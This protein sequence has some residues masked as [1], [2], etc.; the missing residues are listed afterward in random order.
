M[1]RRE[2]VQQRIRLTHVDDLSV[3]NSALAEIAL[4]RAVVGAATFTRVSVTERID[5]RRGT[6]ME[7]M[8]FN[9][10][11]SVGA[12]TLDRSTT[13]GPLRF[14]GCVFR[15][16]VTFAKATFQAPMVLTDGAFDG[17]LSLDAVT[18]LAPIAIERSKTG[19]EVS[20]DSG[21]YHHGL[22]LTRLEATSAV[23]FVDA[24]LLSPFLVEDSTFSGPLTL[25]RLRSTGRVEVRDVTFEDAVSF[26]SG[27]YADAVVFHNVEFQREVTFDSAEF[28]GPV[29]FRDVRFLGPVSFRG[30][31]FGD[32]LRFE[33]VRFD[34]AV[35]FDIEV[36]HLALVNTT[37]A[38]QAS[39][40][41]GNADV[42]VERSRFAAPVTLDSRSTC[43]IRSLAGT[44]ATNLTLAMVDLGVCALSDVY[45]LDKLRVEAAAFPE[46]P[47][48]LRFSRRWPWVLKRSK[49][50]IVAEEAM[51]RARSAPAD[52]A[53]L[54]QGF[55][56]PAR[57]VYANDVA[58]VY[59]QLRKAR[60][61]AKDEPNAA[62]FYYGEMEMRRRATPRHSAEGLILR[63]YWLTSGYGLRGL[64]SVAC[65]VVL[66]LVC[67]TLMNRFGFA[68]PHTWP[69]SVV[70]VAD[71]ATK[72]V[73]ASSS[74]RLTGWG[75]AL[76]VVVRLAGPVLLG[77]AILSVRGRA[78]R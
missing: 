57:P 54:L 71:A 35:D 27:S 63:L 32:R 78:K 47:H 28:G 59:R 13:K 67:A 74:D 41:L 58:R 70:H 25:D 36:R 66:L 2:D 43:R 33:H 34:G 17:K 6:L 29:T 24:H 76:Q 69:A 9:K 60:E 50:R 53:P 48:R 8:E 14:T 45:N 18:A 39:L 56:A 49:R 46:A 51:V 64:R 26:H 65:L 12:V 62:D 61:D 75:T 1:G 16:D 5:F 52:W 7:G 3:V 77:L 55:S 15:E 31:R 23:R 22:R 19:G 11:E 21:T 68:D 4:D 38:V 44:D 20:F 73:G 37:F 72:L 40:V 42:V 30:A 10:V